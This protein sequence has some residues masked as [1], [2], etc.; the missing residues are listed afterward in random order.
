MHHLLIYE[1]AVDYL[2]RRME[3][4]P[5]HLKLAWQAVADGTMVL[6][7]AV[8]EPLEGAILLFESDSPEAAKAFAR[9]DPYVLN[10]LV[11]SW[12]VV[13]WHTVVG[14]AASTPVAKP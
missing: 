3:Y 13:P 9:S 1:L 5:A 14:P 12:R 11:R 6:G 7:G 2:E 10:G 4:R 8:G